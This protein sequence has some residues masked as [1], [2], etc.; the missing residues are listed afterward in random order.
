[1]LVEEWEER[2][3]EEWEERDLVVRKEGDWVVMELEDQGGNHC[4]HN[5]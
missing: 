1:M 5:Q 4:H 2:A 3:Q